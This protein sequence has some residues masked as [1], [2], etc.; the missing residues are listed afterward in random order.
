[1]CCGRDQQSVTK[2]NFHFIYLSF[3]IKCIS[4]SLVLDV[5]GLIPQPNLQRELFKFSLMF[6]YSQERFKMLSR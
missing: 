1:M 3:E 5:L 2:P 4:Y 6:D